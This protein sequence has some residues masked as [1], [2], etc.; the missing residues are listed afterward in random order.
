[1]AADIAKRLK[2][3]KR[4]A[5][6]HLRR[7]LEK[8]DEPVKAPKWRLLWFA[9]DGTTLYGDGLYP[10]AKTADNTGKL[11][12]AEHQGI[13]ND[14]FGPTIFFCTWNGVQKLWNDISHAI[15]MPVKE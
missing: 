3:G 14:A 15:P 12:L 13:H 6:I 7:D 5:D 11:F 1:M 4:E 9:N 8:M 2:D 10:D